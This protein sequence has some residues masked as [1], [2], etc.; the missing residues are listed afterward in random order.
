MRVEHSMNSIG[1]LAK[2]PKNSSWPN[3]I[4]G[5]QWTSSHQNCEKKMDYHLSC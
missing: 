5:L 1:A 4:Q 2:S 3:H